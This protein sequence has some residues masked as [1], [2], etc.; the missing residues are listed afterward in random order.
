MF[1]PKYPRV[2][3]TRLY[4]G[5]G[6]VYPWVSDDSLF[7]ICQCFYCLRVRAYGF[8][9]FTICTHLAKRVWILKRNKLKIADK[10]N[11]L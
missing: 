2:A 6:M 5:N 7:R 9:M 4:V 8:G 10:V 1:H 3:N 11:R